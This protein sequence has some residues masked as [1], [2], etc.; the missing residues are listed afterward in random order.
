MIVLVRLDKLLSN[1]SLV[2]LGELSKPFLNPSTLSEDFLKVT[3]DNFILKLSLMSF[4]PI[5]YPCILSSSENSDIT[6]TPVSIPGFV[7]SIPS[8]GT[9]R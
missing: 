4:I 2:N 3:E 6:S 8:F 7:P 9:T 5:V 1:S